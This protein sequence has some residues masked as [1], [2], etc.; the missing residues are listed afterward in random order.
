MDITLPIVQIIA[1][2]GTFLGVLFRTILPY[3]DKLRTDPTIKFDMRY[4]VTFVIT[5]IEA[6]VTTLL[7]F[8]AI[9]TDLLTSTSSLLFV[10][11]A[12]FAWAYTS[13]DIA[14]RIISGTTTAT[15]ASS[16]QA[17]ATPPVTKSVTLI[18]ASIGS[19]RG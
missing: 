19:A 2:L 14:N 10:F 17:T 9:P 6:L 3:L 4:A 12:T 8:A 11:I 18:T 16:T 15:P 7:I 1:F 5:L 13:N